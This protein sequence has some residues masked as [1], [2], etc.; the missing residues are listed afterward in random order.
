MTFTL[1]IKSK[2]FGFSLLGLAFVLAVGATGY[3]F[4]NRLAGAA[5]QI[6]NDGTALRNQLRADMAHDAL[7]A[8][9][10]AA[11]LAADAK[12]PVA[13]KAIKADLAEHADLFRSSLTRLQAL[14]LDAG[15]RKAVESVLPALGSYVQSATSVIEL[16]FTDR[17]A[18][19]ARMT[20]FLRSF[21][22]VEKEMEALS[23]LIEDRSKA[24]NAQSKASSE[25]AKLM[26]AVAMGLSAC[27]LL[28]MSWWTSRSIVG[29]I[30]RAVEIARTVAA[31][32]LSSRIVVRG[33]D[34]TAQLLKALAQMNDS[35]VTLVGTVRQSS[36][37]IADGTSQIATGNLDLSQR[38]EEQASNLQQ[39][40]ASME[41]IS[42]AVATNAQTTHEASAMAMTA[43]ESAAQGGAAMV[44]LVTTMASITLASRKI[45]DIIGV[46]DSIAFQTNILA[47]NAAVEAARAGDQGRGFAVVAAEVRTLAQRSATAAREIQTLIQSTVEKVMVGERHASDAGQ[48]MDDVVQKV[49]RVTTLI[50]DISRA[51]QEQTRGIS[52]VTLAVT[53][54]DQATQSNAALVEQSAAAS[55]SVSKQAARLVDAV[56]QFRL[57]Q[58]RLQAT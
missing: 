7:R 54:L 20:E 49:Q 53:Q 34:E 56:A 12:D 11:L 22:H 55:D 21:K 16:A 30:Q 24:T 52:E 33:N 25:V 3:I 44:Q 32:D 18:A 48:S 41:Q 15:T 58:P 26:I 1:T 28:L 14:P 9:V 50:T 57:S 13:E 8:D 2:L 43:S 23:D 47:L 45:T 27:A 51:T 36:D 5:E 4:A 17:T 35:L 46:I 31:G 6:T 39:T 37:N 40:A 10:L 29:P 19:Q 42:A 38:T